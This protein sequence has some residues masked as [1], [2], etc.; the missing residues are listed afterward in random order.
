MF[1]VADE[2]VSAGSSLQPLK[3]GD[4]EPVGTGFGSGSCLKPAT[5]PEGPKSSIRHVRLAG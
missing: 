2:A 3:L 4:M 1:G 5:G